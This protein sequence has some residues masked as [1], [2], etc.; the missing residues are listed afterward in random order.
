MPEI[1][2]KGSEERDVLGLN[3]D[4]FLHFSSDKSLLQVC[5]VLGPEGG[6]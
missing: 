4:L 1:T 5:G 6:G 2:E 3:T